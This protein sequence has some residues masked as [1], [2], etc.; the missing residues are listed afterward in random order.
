M[1]RNIQSHAKQEPAA[2]IALPSKASFRI[3]GQINSVP[4]K[5]KLKGFIITKPLL[6]EM[7]KALI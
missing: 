1:A 2:K 3:E 6:K 5:K 7:L 4:D